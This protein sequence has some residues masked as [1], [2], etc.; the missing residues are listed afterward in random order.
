MWRKLLGRH[1]RL[2]ARSA[3]VAADDQAVAEQIARGARRRS[4]PGSKPRAPPRLAQL[5]RTLRRHEAGGIRLRRHAGRWPGRGVR[6]DGDRLRAKRASPPPERAQV[7]RIVGLSLPQ[8]VRT[9]APD[10]EPD[11][12]GRRGRRL[13]GGLPRRARKRAAGRTAV[14]GPARIARRLCAMPAGSSASRPASPAAGSPLALPGTASPSCSAS[15]QTADRHPSKPDPAMLEAAMFEAGAAA[16][17]TVMIGDTSFDMAMARAAGVRA[18]GVA[19]GYHTAGGTARRRAPR[20][21][22]RPLP[23]SRR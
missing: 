23:N 3:R 11:A 15:L 19:W 5:M 14:R 9:L 22:P 4:P 1:R 6:R 2:R 21:S 18:I 12:A 20:R 7:R 13:Q 8:A 10:A 16:G 17:E